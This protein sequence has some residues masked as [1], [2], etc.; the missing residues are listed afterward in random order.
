MMQNSIS[1]ASAL[2]VALT[3]LPSST[4]ASPVLS[5]RQAS[6]A[7]MVDDFEKIEPSPKL[8]WVP[9]FQN[10][11]CTRLE[12]PLD[13]EDLAAG[14]TDIAFIKW[15]SPQTSNSSA[16]ATAPQDILLNPGGPGGSGVDYLLKAINYLILAGG[17]QNNYVGFDPRGV[18]NS[19]PSL[20]CFPENQKH[21]QLLYE[22]QQQLGVQIDDPMSVVDVWRRGAAFGE[23]C[24]QYHG[25]NGSARYANTV[26]VATDMLHY[27]ELIAEEKGEDPGKS[28]LWYWGASYGTVLGAT[29]ASL[30]PQRVGR[31]ILDG[32]VDSEDYYAGK[33]ETNLADGDAAVESFF[34]YCFDAG[35]EKCPVWA[36]SPEAIQEKYDAI[37]ESLKEKPAI[38]SN[39]ELVDTPSI[40]T[41]RDFQTLLVSFPYV[42]DIYWP[43]LASALPILE[44]GN[45]DAIA[46]ATLTGFWRD[47]CSPLATQSKQLEPLP[48]ISCNDANGRLLLDTLPKFQDH[49]DMLYNSSRYMGEG[50]AYIGPAQCQNLGFRPPKSQVFEGIPSAK[51]TS[52]PILFASN[53]I[54]PVTPLRSAE[55][56][57][58]MF[59]GAG[60]LVQEAVGHSTQS[61]LSKCTIG[62]FQEYFSTGA[63]P[64]EGTVCEAD[65]LPFQETEGAGGARGGDTLF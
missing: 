35:K 41:Y 31:M 32:V 64:Q 59:G 52:H 18:N 55:K 27:T 56:M 33:W 57:Q 28:E 50:W 44:S 39:P 30:F 7:T 43:A 48:F 42:P 2:L 3:S 29:F 53:T 24:T 12:V 45:A 63:L 9:C 21:T 23:F 4:N 22:R 11:T 62:H 54:D 10:F 65:T 58:G 16:N 19:G 61:T 60:L 13:Y 17:S 46:N 14:T 1:R 5:R 49:V 15:T 36:E 47:T 20:S 34:T 25:V 26:A 38:V 37:I 51:N 8:N 6:N 40:F